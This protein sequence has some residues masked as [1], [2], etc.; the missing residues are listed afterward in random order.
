MSNLSIVN[1]VLTIIIT[2]LIVTCLAFMSV[3]TTRLRDYLA[4]RIQYEE[5]KQLQ[6]DTIDI[7]NMQNDIVNMQNNTLKVLS[8]KAHA[9]SLRTLK[10]INELPPDS[11]TN[12]E[13][14]YMSDIRQML[15][16]CNNIL[17]DYNVKMKQ[18]NI[19]L[20][21]DTKISFVDNKDEGSAR[22]PDI[23]RT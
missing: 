8:K 3:A 18:I 22:R 7:V 2:L 13:L 9:V 12:R 10:Y 14:D 15:E 4:L 23:Q 21:E 1:D 6:D 20:D 19:K 5:I 17:D 16:K 11:T